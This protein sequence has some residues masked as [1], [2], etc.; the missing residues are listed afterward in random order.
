[1]VNV[2]WLSTAATAAAA[3]PWAK[4]FSLLGIWHDIHVIAQNN[5]S[6]IVFNL[7]YF[8]FAF[9]LL[10]FHRDSVLDSINLGATRRLEVSSRSGFKEC[11][12]SSKEEAG[13]SACKCGKFT[14]AHCGGKRAI[15]TCVSLTHVIFYS[16]ELA[17]NLMVHISWLPIVMNMDGVP[18]S[19]SFPL[20]LCLSHSTNGM[21]QFCFALLDT[22]LGY[23]VIISV[24]YFT[25]GESITKHILF[26]WQFLFCVQLVRNIN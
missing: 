19:L 7:F 15:K 14:C 21:R 24:V 8:I 3:G 10:Y 9:P 4:M 18:L 25:R 26:Q 13:D 11:Q 16:N 2:M 20:L 6:D 5:N 1:M 17:V 22:W 12:H 23:Y